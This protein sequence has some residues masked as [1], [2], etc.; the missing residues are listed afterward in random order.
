[1]KLGKSLVELAQEIE[2]RSNAKKDFV[3]PTD[4]LV[5]QPQDKDVALAFGDQN[6]IANDLAHGQI[7]QHV[8]IPK[9]YY[10]RMRAESPELLAN[11]INTWFQKYPAPRMVRTLDGKARAFLSDRFRPLENEDLAEAVLPVLSDLKVQIMS[12]EITD[13]RLYIKVVDE[14]IQRD[15]PSGKKMGD[16]THTFFDTVSPA[17]VISN[18]E[19]GQ[20]MLAVQTS[21][22][23]KVCTNMAIFGEKS[24]K[25][26]HI[27]GKHELGGEEF[28]KLLSDETRRVSDQALWMQV[29][30][31]VKGAFDEARFVSLTKELSGMA[32]QKID[33][34][35]KVVEL[36]SKKF[37]VNETEKAS[38]LKHL[39]EGGDLSRYG[40]FNAVTRTA[41]DLEDYDRA[42]EFER[43]GGQIVELPRSE[44]AELAMAA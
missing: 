5:A 34:P 26:H 7:A 2:R 9:Q 41:E 29:R 6:V 14:R 19:V 20:G 44:W 11:N 37:G 15:I 36:A 38:V 17:M 22:W 3:V 8:G 28:Y 32:A 4:K 21:L 24:I 16:G 25:K 40:L 18:S 1:M 33:D 27:G 43:M 39:I 30:D 12:C 10:D 13:R 23:T 35:I 42:T 31:V